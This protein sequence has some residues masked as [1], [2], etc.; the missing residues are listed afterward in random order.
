MQSCVYTILIH[1][2]FYG[3]FSRM[4]FLGFSQRSFS[5]FFLYW[6]SMLNDFFSFF[7]NVM[8]ISFR[9]VDHRKSRSISW[10]PTRCLGS[11]RYLTGHHLAWEEAESEEEPTVQPPAVANREWPRAPSVVLPVVY[12]SNATARR[13]KPTSSRPDSTLRGTSSWG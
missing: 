2:V 5:R 9:L 10:W 4:N 1:S 12:S 3:T 8:I 13:P 7:F 6:I 11:G